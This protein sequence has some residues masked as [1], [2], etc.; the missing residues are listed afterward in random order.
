[1]IVNTKEELKKIINNSNVNGDLNNLDVSNVTNMKDFGILYNI[2]I[3]NIS[4]FN[5]YKAIMDDFD[6]KI[7]KVG[8][9]Q[10]LFSL[11]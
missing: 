10:H 8:L 3:N 6:R 11:R 4:D 5:K 1:M 7:Q 9:Y 2:D